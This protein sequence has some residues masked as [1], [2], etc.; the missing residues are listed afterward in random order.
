[1]CRLL[2]AFSLVL[3]AG[4]LRAAGVSSAEKFVFLEPEKS[5]FWRTVTSREVTIPVEYPEGATKAT[6]TVEGLG[7]S[8]TNENITGGSTSVTLPEVTSPETEDVYLFTLAFDNGVTNAI[9]LGHIRG[10]GVDGEGAT[11]FRS[12]RSEKRHWQGT[13][14]RS[15]LPIPYGAASL[16]VD[17]GDPIALDGA[18]GWLALPGLAFGEAC[19]L[20]LTVGE[21]EYLATVIGGRTLGML[22]LIK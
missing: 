16:T 9:P 1:M 10:Y 17:D 2:F 14:G 19:D 22:L 12:P 8:V 13:D 21:D 18:Q 3:A 15:V 20:K 4:M 11:R 5:S 7:F 6:L